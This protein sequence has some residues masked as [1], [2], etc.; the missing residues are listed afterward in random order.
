MDLNQALQIQ[1]RIKQITVSKIQ[2]LLRKEI[3]ANQKEIVEKVRDRW[4]KGVRPN[5]EI[6]GT[7]SLFS[8]EQ[9]KRSRNPL[10]GGNVDLIDQGDLE[11]GLVVNALGGSLFTIFSKDEKAQ[12]ISQKYGLDV[13]GLTEEEKF[14]VLTEAGERVNIKLFEFVGI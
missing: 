14:Q 2:S 4:K 11:K 13:F 6:I 12:A 9:E 1:S 10:A 7:Y 3:L 5:G 8:Y